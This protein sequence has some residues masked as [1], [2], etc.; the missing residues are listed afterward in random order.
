MHLTTI[1]IGYF[2]LSVFTV[3]LSAWI[4]SNFSVGKVLGCS[5][6]SWHVH[7]LCHNLHHNEN[8]LNFLRNLRGLNGIIPMAI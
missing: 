4:S 7:I 8:S 3:H 2:K 1:L 6:H 5:P